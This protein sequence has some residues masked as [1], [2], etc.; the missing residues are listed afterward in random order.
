MLMSCKS[1]K[2]VTNE[3]ILWLPY[4][5][6]NWEIHTIPEWLTWP[7]V[8]D[9]AINKILANS[10]VLAGC[11]ATFV[12][13]HFTE[14]PRK[15]WWTAIKHIYFKKTQDFVTLLTLLF[16]GLDKLCLRTA[17]FCHCLSE[18]TATF[19]VSGFRKHNS[20]VFLGCLDRQSGE[21]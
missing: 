16:C 11:W 21:Q 20:N 19:F 3:E 8:A 2:G 6:V 10:A 1:C 9:V 17:A 14:I 18:N 12:N 4:L 7:A 15:T 5:K 13:V